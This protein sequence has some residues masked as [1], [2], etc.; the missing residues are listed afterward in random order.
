MVAIAI[1]IISSIMVKPADLANP[2]PPAF[3]LLVVIPILV[4]EVFMV[5]MLGAQ[6]YVKLTVVSQPADL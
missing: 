1:V 2:M 5:W 3:G 4:S 6:P